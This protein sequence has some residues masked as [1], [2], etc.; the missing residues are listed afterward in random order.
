[1]FEQKLNGSRR[2]CRRL[3]VILSLSAENLFGVLLLFKISS[4]L[5][6]STP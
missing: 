6:E 2:K 4:N 1:M 3:K 5:V